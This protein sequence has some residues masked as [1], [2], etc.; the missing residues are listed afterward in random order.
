MTISGSGGDA[1]PPCARAPRTETSDRERRLVAAFD[2]SRLLLVVTTP[3]GVVVE[4][5]RTAL[6]FAEADAAELLGLPLPLT[7]WWRRAPGAEPE[8]LA[9]LARARAGAVVRFEAEHRD[10]RGE[11]RVVAYVVQPIFDGD[12]V[13]HLLVEGQ[14]ETE[15]RRAEE[16]SAGARRMLELVLD[17]I[18]V[19]VFWKDRELRYLGCNG[20]FAADAGLASAADIVGKDDRE[21]S[22]RERA[23][24]Y[25]TGDR[26]VIDS[27]VGHVAEEPLRPQDGSERWIRVYKIPLRDRDDRVVGVL[28]AYEDITDRKRA[29]DERLRLELQMQHA[30]KLESL[31]V[32]AGGIAHDFNNLLMAMRGNLDVLEDRLRGR[33]DAEETLGAIDAAIERATDLSRQ[34]LAYSGRGRFVVRPVELSALV[35]EMASLLRVS[36]T[37]KA[38]LVLELA[39]GLPLVHGDVA[40]LQQVVMNL[41]TNASEAL[42]DGEGTIRVRTSARALGA[43]EIREL[44]DEYTRTEL[45]PGRYVAL[46]VEDTGSGIDPATRAR[47]FEP[48]F[49]TKFTGRGLGLA[50]VLGIV[51]GHRG[52]VRVESAPGEGTRFRVLLP[53]S[54]PGAA[55]VAPASARAPAGR[56]RG[57]GTVLLAEDEALVS[58][59]AQTLLR[60]LGLEVVSV[61]DGRAALDAYEPGRFACVI[62]DVTMPRMDGAAAFRAI[63]ARD[64]VAKILLASGYDARDVLPRLGDVQPAAFLGK[65]FSLAELERTLRAVLG[66]GEGGG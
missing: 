14:D 34:M 5:N 11:A 44:R 26:A 50:A 45:P 7:G 29:E 4:A 41:I 19:R 1:P 27:G 55:L 56:W 60:H 63:R 61:G 47:M 16:A 37:K 36:V 65:P 52:S 2:R 18:P 46:E 39:E 20:H 66:E 22:W 53:A 17:T 15:R 10:A 33:L 58:A 32:L 48:F 43:E 40:Q 57:R 59:A 13:A 9:A 54:E 24:I 8:L 23:D 49:T 21:L 31:G 25:R 30:Q 12:V 42:A 64:P 6:A 35:R 51:R 3:E 62:L 38:A 28:G